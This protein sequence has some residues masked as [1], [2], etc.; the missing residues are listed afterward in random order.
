MRYGLPVITYMT[1]RLTITRAVRL[2]KTKLLPIDVL[3]RR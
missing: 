2:I 3:R 1:E